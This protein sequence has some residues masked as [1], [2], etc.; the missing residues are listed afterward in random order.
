MNFV[1]C[2]EECKITKSDK[3]FKNIKKKN[4]LGT[5]GIIFSR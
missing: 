5:R 3:F 1:G 4:S 2:V